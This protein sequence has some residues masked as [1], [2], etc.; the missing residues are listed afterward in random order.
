M[1]ELRLNVAHMRQT[2]ILIAGAG[3]AGSAAAA[4]L[5]RAGVDVLVV[6]PHTVY[7]PDFRCEKLDQSQIEILKKTGLA[8]PVLSIATPN[9]SLWVA[10]FGRLVEKLK[11]AQCGLMYD[12]LVNT[13]RGEIPPAAFIAAKVTAL[14][15]G[16]D[17][18]TVMLSNGQ[19]I[20]ARLVVMANGLNIGLRHQLGIERKI[21]SEAHSIS[22]G[23]DI[24]PMGSVPFE[25]SALTYFP[26]NAASRMAYLTL[27]PIGSSTRAN[28]FVYRDM[29][30]PWLSEFRKAPKQTMLAMIPRLEKLTGPFDVDGLVKI[31][32]VDLYVNDS[33]RQAGVVL[34]GDAFATSC[35]AAGTGAGKAL[36]DVERLCNI[37]IPQWLA[38]PGMDAGKIAS[39]YDD[40]IKSAYDAWC[41]KK[42]YALKS[43]SIDRSPARTV[44]RWAKFALQWL[45]G[46]LHEAP[47]GSSIEA[48][49]LV[50]SQAPAGEPAYEPARARHTV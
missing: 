32:P 5:A 31:R 29:H 25:F 14:T 22:I 38:T 2:D 43:F 41:L 37:H 50:P 19:Q 36:M 27:F 17:R 23:F 11:G 34:V 9:R 44:E 28:L 18:Q 6:D 8:G 30:D 21:L 12:T 10:R 1:K 26:E 42:A 24:K 46:A 4:M 3:L 20:S 16:E 33:Y 15:T 35:P 47:D 40:P 39:F 7:P 48:P 45:K 49:A 13:V